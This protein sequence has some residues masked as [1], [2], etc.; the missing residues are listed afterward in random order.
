MPRGRR[1]K[2]QPNAGLRPQLRIQR[3]VGAQAVGDAE[4]GL[5]YF[6]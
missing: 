5:L 3:A 6:T 1:L 4:G 2:V